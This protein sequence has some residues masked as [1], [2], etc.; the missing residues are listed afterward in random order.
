VDFD[1]QLWRVPEVVFV[2]HRQEPHLGLHSH[3][4]VDGRTSVWVRKNG[5]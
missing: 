4:A 3:G 5:L 2:L 1:L